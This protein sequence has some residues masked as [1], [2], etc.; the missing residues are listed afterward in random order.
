MRFAFLHALSSYRL[1][2]AFALPPTGRTLA[3]LFAFYILTGLFWHDPWVS[4][5][6]IHLAVASNFV[7]TWPDLSLSLAEQPFFAPPLYYWSAALTHLLTSWVLPAHDALRL[8]NGIWMSIVLA[9]LY[10]AGREMYGKDAAVPP[11][12]LA[13]SI[14]LIVHA[15]EA[16]P[17][18]AVLAAM[19]LWLLFVALL[20]R[21]PK[22]AGITLILAFLLAALSGGL[23][24]WLLIFLFFLAGFAVFPVMRREAQ[25]LLLAFAGSL[26]LLAVAAGILHLTTPAWFASWG[27][28]ELATLWQHDWRYARDETFLWNIMS[29]FTWP[30]WPLAGW[31]LWRNRH[32]LDAPE[33]LL[34][35]ACFIIALVFLP[36]GFAVRRSTAILL[37]PP[38]ALLATPGVLTLRSSA[39]SAFDWFSGAVFTVF[40]ILLWVGWSAMVLGYPARLNDHATVLNP[41]FTGHFDAGFFTLAIIVTLW[42]LWLAL[43]MPRSPYR[44]LIRWSAGLFSVWGLAVFLWL[45]WIDHERSY[46]NMSTA[47]VAQL[48]PTL[49]LGRDCLAVWQLDEAQI[50]SLIY[51]TGLRPIPLTGA[52]THCGWLLVEGRRSVEPL[53]AHG[54]DWQRVWEGHRPGERRSRFRLY[55][56]IDKHNMEA[57]RN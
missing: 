1:P 36:V 7:A 23:S 46:R 16:Q 14:G 31:A 34:P 49:L 38:L 9:S 40:A 45:P 27:Q 39:A 50:A 6:I 28:H 11:L 44:C 52:S 57:Q 53:P 54:R 20:P 35:L 15:H 18:V 41:G 29:W 8:A 55:R 33:I 56:R 2:H 37:L 26:L 12:L 21:K 19:S 48:P 24:G 47:L 42:W 30:V 25:R 51:F 43:S 3:G 4:E 22:A 10:Y 13:G 17:L 5:D 32:R